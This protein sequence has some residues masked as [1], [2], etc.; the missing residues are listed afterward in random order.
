MRA[1]IL[2]SRLFLAALTLLCTAN[3][4]TASVPGPADNLALEFQKTVLEL[5]KDTSLDRSRAIDLYWKSRQIASGKGDGIER[6]LGDLYTQFKSEHIGRVTLSSSGWQVQAPA[7]PM[8]LTR[9]LKFDNLFLIVTND[10]EQQ[11]QFTLRSVDPDLEVTPVSLSVAPRSSSGRFLSLKSEREGVF[12]AELRIESEDSSATLRLQCDTRLSGRL[13]VH[14]KDGDGNATAARIFL[15][16]SDGY[17]H[18]PQNSLDRIMWRSGEHF[19]YADKTIQIDLPAGN[20]RLEVCK[21][22]DYEPLVSSVLIKPGQITNVGLRLKHV[23]DMN[24]RGW[25]S[26]DGHIHGNYEGDQFITP[27]DDFL[28]IRAEDLNVGNAVVSNSTGGVVHDERYFEG[29]PNALSSKSH[30]LYWNQE[31]RTNGP[32]GHLLF[33]NLRQL[34]QPLETG[35]PGSENWEDY[36]SNYAQAMKAKVQGGFTAYAHPALAFDRFPTTPTLAGESVVDVALG[37]ID[38]FEVFCS[39]D[40]PSMALWYK[41]LNSGFRLGITAGSDAFINQR[42]ALVTGGTR[43]YVHTGKRFDYQS[44]ISNLSQGRAF[45]TAGPLLIFEI[46]NKLPGEEFHFAHG[47][48]R[49][50]AKASVASVVPITKLEIVAN[51]KVVHSVSSEAPTNKLQWD[52][53]IDLPKSAWVAARVWGPDHRLI[54]NSPSRWAENRSSLVLLAHTGAS[55]IHIGDDPIYSESDL[56]FLI[57]WIDRLSEIVKKQGKFSDEQKRKEVIETFLRARRV[58]ERKKAEAALT[59]H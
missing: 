45:A 59:S 47:P 25:Y 35:F 24:K 1:S 5:T 10:T 50:K 40:E 27:E 30:I 56:E 23:L 20:A 32:Y 14:L 4:R 44:W 2:L 21:G 41:F 16:A 19:F 18:R 3:P 13:V 11:R 33:Y 53:T 29:R 12:Q 49:L 28:V 31:M 51:G 7:A 37:S 6:S 38:A 55:Y 57:G 39:H 34:V 15:T 58:Y 22:F 17:S 43:V 48:I 8:I 46:E 54:A 52:G 9:G 36:P 26:G 42:F